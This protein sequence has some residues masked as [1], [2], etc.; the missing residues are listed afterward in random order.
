MALVHL[1]HL[2]L[3]Q[4]QHAFL[5]EHEVVVG[6]V[7]QPVDAIHHLDDGTTFTFRR[8]LLR[9]GGGA[10]AAASAGAHAKLLFHPCCEVGGG[11]AVVLVDPG[12]AQIVVLHF[13]NVG[14]LILLLPLQV[15]LDELLVVRV[16]L[17]RI[18]NL[19]TDRTKLPVRAYLA[20][21]DPIYVI[22]L[23]MKLSLLRTLTCHEVILIEN[24]NMP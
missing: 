20:K 4:H 15:L 5:V 16:F 19:K 13:E 2:C 17:G 8:V 18:P 6:V 24:I 23:H 21:L 9:P 3:Q 1:V 10:A 7:V 11:E 12:V 22:F 14:H